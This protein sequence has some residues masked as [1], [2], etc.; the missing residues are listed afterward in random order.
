MLKIKA[1]IELKCNT[2][3]TSVGDAFCERLRGNYGVMGAG[4]YPEEL[5][6]LVSRPPE[7][8]LGEGGIT[9]L[10]SESNVE[11]RQ[12]NKVE[13][14][15][16]FLNR[17]L[18][19]AEADLTYQDR[20]F[21]T[22]VLNQLGIK[23]EK[24]F[25][26]QVHN[27]K[28]EINNTEELVNLYWNNMTR[29]ESMVNEYREEA[30]ATNITQEGDTN[31]T[32]LHLHEDIMNRL[33]TGAVYQIVQNFSKNTAGDTFVTN[34]EYRLSEQNRITQNIL[35]NRLQNVVRH[36]EMPLTF[37]HENIYEE[38]VYDDTNVTEE[39]VNTRINSA[40]LLNLIDNL[41]QTRHETMQ[42]GG[43][44]TYRLESAFYEGADNTINRITQNVEQ[45]FVYAGN[46]ENTSERVDA[47]TEEINI[48]NN[49]LSENRTEVLKA[50]TDA[51]YR[52]YRNTN[53]RSGDTQNLSFASNNITQSG[54]T[55]IAG[56]NVNISGDRITQGDRITNEGD[57]IVH[58]E[59]DTTFVDETTTEVENINRELAMINEQN[60]IRNQEFQQNLTRISQNF[61]QRPKEISAK[62]AMADSLLALEHPGEFLRKVREEE[63]TRESE[64]RMQE[65][66]VIEILP[67]RERE[68]TRLLRQYLERPETFVGQTVIQENNL[69]QLVAD[70]SRVE[71]EERI[72]EQKIK[73][74]RAE[75]E[76]VKEVVTE[77]VREIKRAMPEIRVDERPA[78]RISLVHKSQESVVDEEILEEI[79]QQN[80]RIEQQNQRIDH[81]VTNNKT[82]TTTVVQNTQH[83]T[84][85]EQSNDVT[86]A[87]Q[88]SLNGQMDSITEKVYNKL[89]KRLANEK[90]R[91]GL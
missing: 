70:V 24:H 44:K 33:M 52:Q 62:R 30:G 9:N 53:Y 77:T 85:V 63:E 41:Y 66:A 57:L 51:D 68:T 55:V 64:E 3:V 61:E 76:T 12:V 90:I 19:N 82:E 6:H 74:E 75:Q 45:H 56:D 89:T 54:D 20:V 13:I 88:R 27:I 32:E 38:T 46:V 18:V 72:R 48:V 28:N 67:E 23:D 17:V 10:V 22:N 50:L 4:L 81:I 34:E 42:R 2:D 87:V 11:N 16:N 91:R 14:I 83:N 79:L 8:Y 15:N 49:I 73:Q 60:L 25:M 78:E 71:R 59:G 1:P 47:L 29:L 39:S 26:Q 80:R 5:M 21:I 69:T 31:V 35:L 43:D 86:E 65:N 84:I 37:R 40:V 58:A 36:E 7:I